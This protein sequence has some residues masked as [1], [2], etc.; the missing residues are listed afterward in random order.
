MTSNI[1][2]GMTT[3]SRVACLRP[4]LLTMELVRVEC[5]SLVE[6]ALPSVLCTHDGPQPEP[7]ELVSSEIRFLHF[8]LCLM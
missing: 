1:H 5:A 6:C 4:L 2:M 7:C 3:N 8:D